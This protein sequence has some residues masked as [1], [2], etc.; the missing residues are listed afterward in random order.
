M[1]Q[2]LLNNWNFIRL[3]RLGMGI[4]IVVQ[5]VTVRDTFLCII[6]LLLAV[7]ALF[8]AGCCGAGNCYTPVNKA[9][10]KDKEI[11]YE[12]VMTDK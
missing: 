2:I 11:Y 4:A 9:V 6:G 8:N 12:E 3:L 5:A 10:D 7:M 1:K